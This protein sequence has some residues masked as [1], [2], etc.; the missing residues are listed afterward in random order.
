MT[1]I[2]YTPQ[3]IKEVQDVLSGKRVYLMKNK[4]K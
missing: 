3:E 1:E 2:T 4:K